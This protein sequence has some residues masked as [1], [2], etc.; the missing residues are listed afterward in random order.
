MRV[1][2]AG[3]SRVTR[4]SC[5]VAG[6]AQSAVSLEAL[7]A[8]LLSGVAQNPSI[9]QEHIRLVPLLSPAGRC[10]LLSAMKKCAPYVL[11]VQPIQ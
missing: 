9:R 7:W 3:T 11:R 4:C 2:E 6:A 10:L 1:G 5:R 8:C